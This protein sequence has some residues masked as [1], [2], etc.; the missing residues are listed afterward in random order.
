[1]VEEF[2]RCATADK[3]LKETRHKTLS[4]F[5]L[6]MI[7]SMF[8]SLKISHNVTIHISHLLLRVAGKF[9]KFQRKYRILMCVWN[10]LPLNYLSIT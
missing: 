3:T 1:M 6:C 5:E 9:L 2:S 10:V 7:A 8:N 4:G